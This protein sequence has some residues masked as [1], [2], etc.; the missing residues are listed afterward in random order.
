MI[1]PM[2][3]LAKMEA[4]WEKVQRD[5]WQRAY[6]TAFCEALDQDMA[7]TDAETYALNKVMERSL[8][9]RQEV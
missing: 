8:S 2:T 5:A 4:H 7:M 3:I 6:D 9:M 1:P